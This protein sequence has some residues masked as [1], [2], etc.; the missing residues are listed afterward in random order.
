MR[1][2]LLKK[3]SIKEHIKNM[4]SILKLA[5][6]MNKA[7]FYIM[8]IVHILNAAV[9]YITL[10]LSAYVL[11]SIELK[12]DFRQVMLVI[13]G[14]LIFILLIQFVA[15]TL[16][17]RMQIEKDDMYYRYFCNIETKMLSMDYSRINSPEVEQLKKRITEDN[18]WGSG[19][20][21]IL[22]GFDRIVYGVINIIGAIII[23]APVMQYIITSGAYGVLLLLAVF[24]LFVCL[25]FKLRIHFKKMDDTFMYKEESREDY[26]QMINFGWNFLVGDGYNYKN[27]KD[28]RI[29]N[30]YDL[31]RKWTIGNERSKKNRDA[32]RYGSVGLGGWCGIDALIRG[33]ME[34]VAYLAVVMVALAGSITVGNVVRLAGCLKNLMQAIYDLITMVCDFA[35]A[36]RKQMST[37]ELLEL[38]NEMYAGKLPVEKRSDNEYQIEFK[39]V[40]F[41]YPGTEKYALKDFSMKLKIGEKLAIVGMNG[42]G[43]TTMIKLLCRLY[44]PDE[45]EILLNGVNIKK[46]KQEEYVQLFSVVFQDYKLFP[47]KLGEN[48]AVDTEYDEIKVRDC[49]IKAGFGDRLDSLDKGLETYLTKQ[50]DDDGVEF[51]GGEEQ[52]L[53]IA[54]AIYKEAPFI[55]LDEPTA[56]LDP[57]AEYEIYSSFDKIIGTKTAI[58]ISHRLSSCRFCKKIAVFDEGRLV[59]LGSHDELVGNQSGKYYEMWNAQAKYYQESGIEFTY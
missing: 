55:L 38:E 14:T 37:L 59:Q 6:D 27:G 2:D 9:P 12:R 29:Y 30:S 44:D 33:G 13:C 17:N 54:R 43:K 24:V 48:V 47:F 3:I 56:A 1:T 22:Y 57:I 8:G 4:K 32:I 46:F 42:S 19:L 41:K 31:L 15:S 18:N 39:N 35:M 58:Y 28:V 26:A 21:G 52:K 10:V 40:S 36:A 34:G 51:S 50:Y 7:Y 45:G 5:A 16:Y 53:A 25:M 49:L 20:Y 23:G 11:D